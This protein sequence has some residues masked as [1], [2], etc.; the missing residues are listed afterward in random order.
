MIKLPPTIR[1]GPIFY[2]ILLDDIEDMGEFESQSSTIYLQKDMEGQQT[3]LTLLHE[4]THAMLCESGLK[5]Y[6][7]E[8]LVNIISAGFF[9]LLIDNPE[10]V[11]YF[12]ENAKRLS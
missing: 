11:R 2:K 10:I 7:N 3:M 12:M 9:S 4:A 5:E 6:E 8:I 1:I